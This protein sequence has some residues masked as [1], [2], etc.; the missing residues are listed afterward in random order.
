MTI[1]IIATLASILLLA[2]NRI[3][4][5]IANSIRNWFYR[6]DMKR[7][8]QMRERRALDERFEYLNKDIRDLRT[9][10]YDL[11]YVVENVKNELNNKEN[12]KNVKKKKRN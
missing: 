11:S 1:L 4:W 6:R 3:G 8:E 2:L 12:K 7:D 5:L 10:M 9:N